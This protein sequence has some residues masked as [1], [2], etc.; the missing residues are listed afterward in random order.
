MKFNTYF[1]SEY[2]LVHQKVFYSP[3]DEI[4]VL[5]KIIAELKAD[6]KYKKDPELLQ[7]MID[8]VILNAKAYLWWAKKEMNKLSA[9]EQKIIKKR[10]GGSK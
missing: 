4:Q 5:D 3:F 6:E 7:I 2:P 8:S 1:N 9:T 10:G